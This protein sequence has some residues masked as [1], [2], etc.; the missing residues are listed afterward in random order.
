MVNHM[1]ILFQR[2]GFQVTQAT[3]LFHEFIDRRYHHWLPL[4]IC[5]YWLEYNINLE[6][7]PYSDRSWEINDKNVLR[8]LQ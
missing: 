8:V 7:G 3:I 1:G 2:D 4:G 5:S 6:L